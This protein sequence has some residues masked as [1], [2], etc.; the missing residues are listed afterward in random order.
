MVNST[1]L[2]AKVKILEDEV[3]T[4]RDKVSS[5]EEYTSGWVIPPHY[6]HPITGK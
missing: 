5:L 6:R 2:E 4:L 1:E 3:R